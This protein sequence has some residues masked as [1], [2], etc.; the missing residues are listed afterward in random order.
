M[1]PYNG[2]SL[3][4]CFDGSVVALF[5]GSVHSPRHDDVHG[6]ERLITGVS[7]LLKNPPR[8]EVATKVDVAGRI[9]Q[10]QTSTIQAVL[11][12]IRNAFIKAILPGFDREARSR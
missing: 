4:W 3:H 6:R 9:D 11:N 8:D 7:K 1:C 2:C 12:L 5:P 10:P